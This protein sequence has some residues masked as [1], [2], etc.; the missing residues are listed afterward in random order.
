MTGPA[1][2]VHS[3]PCRYCAFFCRPGND[4]SRKRPFCAFTGERLSKEHA[5]PGCTGFHYRQYVTHEG[6]IWA[7]T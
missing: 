7:T 3:G 1:F 5:E 6:D 4:R 2:G